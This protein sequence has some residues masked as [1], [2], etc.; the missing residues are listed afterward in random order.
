MK[1]LN[2]SAFVSSYPRTYRVDRT[3]KTVFSVLAIL[4]LSGAIKTVLE[5][6]GLK[7]HSS[8]GGPL[9]GFCLSVC[10]ALLALYTL[11][12]EVTLFE[13]AIEK[14]TWFSR[15]RLNREEILGWRGEYSARY[16]GYTYILVPRDP[17]TG[18]MRLPAFFRWDKTFFQWKKSVPQ[19]KK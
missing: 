10:F 2:Q 1:N 19:L 18:N 7:K 13:D 3:I 11:S 17:R 4:F 16:P 9:F 14:V 15:Q 6:L 5:L 8:I 12:I